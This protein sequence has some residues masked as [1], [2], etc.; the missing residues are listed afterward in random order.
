MAA[1]SCKPCCGRLTRAC[2]TKPSMPRAGNT[3]GRNPSQACMRKGGCSI[4]A[5]FPNLR[6]RCAPSFRAASIARPT[7]WTRW[8]TRSPS[9]WWCPESGSC[10]RTSPVTTGAKTIIT[11]PCCG[12]TAPGM[13]RNPRGWPKPRPR[14]SRGILAAPGAAGEHFDRFCEGPEMPPAPAYDHGGVTLHTGDVR[15][16]LPTLA[17]DS[18]QCVV[19]SPP[20][21]G[22]RSY[23]A[24]EHPDKALEMGGEPTPDDYVHE[25]VAVFRDVRRVLRPDGTAWVELGDSYAGA[26]DSNH[27]RPASSP[28]GPRV[29]RGAGP[30]DGLGAVAGYKPKDLLGMPWRVALALQADGWWLRSAVIWSKPNPMPESVGDRPTTAHSYVFLLAA[31]ERYFYDAEAIAESAAYGY[32]EGGMRSGAYLNNHAYLNSDMDYTKRTVGGGDGGTRNA[33]SV[34]TIPTEPFPEAHF[35]T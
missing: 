10:M 1:I 22:L 24:G 11:P 31:G 2:P 7:G 8:C 34:W 4:S 19:T 27:V 35:A 29:H 20:F 21:F 5:A 30:R 26:G 32:R 23:L 3:S 6:S 14:R 16:V 25:L 9:S 17:A 18:V 12:P 33:R 15:A 28:D 13:A